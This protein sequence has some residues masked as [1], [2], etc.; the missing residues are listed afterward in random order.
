KA[1]STPT[2]CRSEGLGAAFRLAHDH[3]YTEEAEKYRKA[4]KEAIKFQL[5]MHLKPESVMYYNN[6]KFCLGG[7]H[8]SLTNYEIRNDYTQHNISSFIS[9]YN[10]LKHY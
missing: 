10:I 4:I 2:A 7:V 8:A 9:Y 6:K 1:P 3:N 5:Q